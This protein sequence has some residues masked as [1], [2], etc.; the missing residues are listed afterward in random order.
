MVTTWE[1][2]RPGAARSVDADGPAEPRYAVPGTPRQLVRRQRLTSWLDDAAAVPLTLVSAPAGSGKTTLV[3]DWVAQCRECRSV[4]WIT[5]SPG[6]DRPGRFWRLVAACVRRCGVALPERLA[7]GVPHRRMLTELSAALAAMD[8][9]VH[10][11]LDGLEISDARLSA[12]LDFVLAHSGRRLR[13]LILTRLDPVLP[14]HRYRLD[15]T[16]VELRMSD[17]AFT[18]EETSRLLETSGVPLGDEALAELVRRTRGWAVGLRF[19]TMLLA[20][21]EDPDAAVRELAGDRGNIGE[22]LMAEMLRTQPAEVRTLMLR[23]SV[24][25][26]LEPGLIEELAGRSAPR[27]LDALARANVLVEESPERPGCYR[28]HPLLRDLLRAELGYSSPQLLTRLQRR[29]AGWLVQRGALDEAV[30]LAA[31]AGAWSEA[32]DYAVEGL[33]V[34]RLATGEDGVLADALRGLPSQARGSSAAVVRA[35]LALADDDTDLCARELAKARSSADRGGP[36]VPAVALAIEVVDSLRACYAD[37][38]DAGE[39]AD[40]A[41]AGVA[42]WRGERSADLAGYAMLVQTSRGVAQVRRGD[43]AAGR[44]TL[45]VAARAADESACR[46]L[47][48]AA[49]AHLALVACLDGRLNDA[50]E[51][52]SRA[53]A[54]AERT[55]GPGEQPSIARVALAWVSAERVDLEAGRTHLGAEARRSDPLTRG[56]RAL[57]RGRLLRGAGDLEPAAEVL[58]GAAEGLSVRAAWLSDLIAVEEAQTNTARGHTDLALSLL[59][60]LEEPDRAAAVVARARAQLEG[61]DRTDLART[62]TTQL[63]ALSDDAGSAEVDAGVVEAADHLVAGRRQAAVAALGR[64]LRRAAPER[65]RRPF[66]EAPRSVRDLL[67]DDQALTAPHP[68]LGLGGTASTATRVATG[69]PAESRPGAWADDPIIEP[70]TARETEVLSHLSDLLTTEEIAATM[71]VSVNTVRTHVRNILRKLAVSRRNEA[72]RRGRALSLLAD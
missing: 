48:V 52:A 16:M 56:L 32:A 29:A 35:A 7:S 22:Y 65:V 71:F 28:Y 30:S 33:A 38:E 68:W 8:A 54:L 67:Q 5:C 58:Q 24:V 19:A 39:T 57:V 46:P 69:E 34:G 70:L 66:R 36:R 43:H 11:V 20:R 50:H 60:G 41:A 63:R 47:P 59:Q 40:R 26:L 10:L 31:A 15:E 13:L 53:V 25:D 72:V 61:G 4:G 23:T 18:S 6:D 27:A 3:A 1:G 64:S 62:V 37:D 21:S 51:H 49:H 17:L 55:Q 12:D 2:R 45:E 44:E 14:L 9:P 42:A